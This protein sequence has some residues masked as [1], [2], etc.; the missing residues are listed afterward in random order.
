MAGFGVRLLRVFGW[1]CLGL[2][3]LIVLLGGRLVL[4]EGWLV[5][6]LLAPLILLGALLLWLGSRK[7][8]LAEAAIPR[9]KARRLRGLARLSR[10]VGTCLLLA[11]G[12]AL[13]AFVL[14][15]LT[16]LRLAGV[17]YFALFGPFLLFGAILGAILLWL[18]RRLRERAGPTTPDAKDPWAYDPDLDGP[19]AEDL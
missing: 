13:L 2:A 14:V 10:V 18:A 4:R 6:F 12:V 9:E 15:L 16:P 1:A 11:G 3:A 5:A 19:D 17:L 7:P 8:V